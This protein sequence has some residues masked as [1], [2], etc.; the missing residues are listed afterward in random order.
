MQAVQNIFSSK[1]KGTT[2]TLFDLFITKHKHGLVCI[3][4]GIN[5]MITKY[6]T[7]EENV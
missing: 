7:M 3:T 2:Q 1:I 6:N 4:K 5:D